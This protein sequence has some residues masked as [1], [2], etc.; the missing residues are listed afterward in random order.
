MNSFVRL[1]LRT[2]FISGVAFVLFVLALSQ[3]QTLYPDLFPQAGGAWGFDL[4]L[5]TANILWMATLWFIADGGMFTLTYLWK[6]W[7]GMQAT[8]RA[9]Q[10]AAEQAGQQA[11]ERQKARLIASEKTPE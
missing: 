9:G 4:S 8:I 5:S 1:L 11:A 3:L 7:R 10:M 2:F 6:R